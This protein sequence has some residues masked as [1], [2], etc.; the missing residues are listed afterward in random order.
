MRNTHHF[1][2]LWYMKLAFRD[3]VDD[4][5]SSLTSLKGGRSFM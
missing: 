4:W 1:A 2:G 3:M 5:D